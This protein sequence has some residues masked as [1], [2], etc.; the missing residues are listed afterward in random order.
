MDTN[1]HPLIK[2]RYGEGGDFNFIISTMLRGVWGG[3][4]WYQMIPRQIFMKYYHPFLETLILKPD[5]RI[6]VA[7]LKSD[8]DYILGYMLTNHDGSILHWI[9]VKQDERRKGIAKLLLTKFPESVSHITEL[10]INLLPKINNPV[11]NPFKF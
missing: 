2:V 4:S 11:F 1:L 5:S 9:Y 8:P 3:N 6:W 7:C 10:G